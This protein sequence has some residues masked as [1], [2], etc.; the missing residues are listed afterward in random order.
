MGKQG[1]NK[2][3]DKLEV[4]RNPQKIVVVYEF[5]GKYY[6]RYPVGEDSVEIDISEVND[7]SLFCVRFEEY[8]K[9]QDS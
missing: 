4:E 7:A 1:I 5:N 2:R 3:L 8:R 6:D 9:R